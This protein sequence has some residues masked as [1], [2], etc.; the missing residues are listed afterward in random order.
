MIVSLRLIPKDSPY[1]VEVYRQA[2]PGKNSCNRIVRVIWYQKLQ[3][4]A[5]PKSSLS[6]TAA[7]RRSCAAS[8]SIVSSSMSSSLTYLNIWWYVE[9]P[10]HVRNV[11]HL[12]D[13]SSPNTGFLLAGCF[14]YCYSLKRT[15]ILGHICQES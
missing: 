12:C 6:N 2:H 5:R 13:G 15:R 1:L 4:S 10:K 7:P 11:Y 8:H 3:T 9:M 14:P